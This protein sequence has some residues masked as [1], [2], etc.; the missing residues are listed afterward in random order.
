MSGWSIV[1][2][3]V[4]IVLAVDAIIASRIWA[5]V[6]GVLVAAALAAYI[7]YK[8]RSRRIIS[9]QI[10]AAKLDIYLFRLACVVYKGV[11]GSEYTEKKSQAK[12]LQNIL[13]EDEEDN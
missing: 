13:F 6:I 5:I 9:R 1:L 4:I 12:E 7:I 11:S 8:V 3:L 10:Q 2:I